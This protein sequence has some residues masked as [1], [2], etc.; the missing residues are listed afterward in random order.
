MNKKQKIITGRTGMDERKEEATTKQWTPTKQMDQ[1]KHVQ[2]KQLQT[3][4][5]NSTRQV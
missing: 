3:E 4:A 5:Q 1:R 2:L